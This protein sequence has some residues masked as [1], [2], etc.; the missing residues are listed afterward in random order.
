[1]P[2]AGHQLAGDCDGGD[3]LPAASGKTAPFTRLN[4]TPYGSLPTGTMLVT[5]SGLRVDRDPD[6]EPPT[7]MVAV[8]SL[9]R[10]L[11]TDT[12]PPSHLAT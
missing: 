7:G 12:V 1:V 4:A 9:V 6:G 3:L 5:A 10:P 2:G 8:T 11:M